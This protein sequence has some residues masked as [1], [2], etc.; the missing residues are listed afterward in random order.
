MRGKGFIPF[1]LYTER[2]A[3][4]IKRIEDSVM[5]P[6]GLRGSH[7]MCLLRIAEKDGGSSSDPLASACEVDKAFISRITSELKDK[8]Y[9]EKNSPQAYKSKF[10]LTEMGKDIHNLINEAVTSAIETI[11]KD[12]SADKMR[13]FYDVLSKLDD[14]IVDILKKENDYGNE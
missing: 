3:K 4:N 9:I 2:I 7:V 1:I 12:I 5:Q 6:Y 13:T 14:G 8:G 10:V 11:T